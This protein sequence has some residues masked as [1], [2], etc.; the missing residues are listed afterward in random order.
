M[1]KQNERDAIEAF[2][3]GRRVAL[4]LMTRAKLSHSVAGLAEL[5]A[6]V[7][8]RRGAFESHESHDEHVN[9][10]RRYARKNAE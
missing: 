3:Q 7:D 1:T 5:S 4:S 10:V 6:I 2:K 8:L 9:N